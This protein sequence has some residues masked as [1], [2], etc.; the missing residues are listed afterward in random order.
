M[1]KFFKTA[2]LGIMTLAAFEGKAQND[3]N[4]RSIKPVIDIDATEVKSQDRTGTCWSFATT[5]FIESELIRMGKGA[6]NISEMY[7]VR[8]V[9]P[10]KAEVYVR[11]HGKAQFGE[12]SLAH[13]VINSVREYGMVPE[14]VYTG[15]KFDNR[16]NHA[17]MSNILKK[18]LQ[19]VVE[20]KG[21][22]LSKKWKEA[23]NAVLDVYMG[24]APETFEYEGKMYT[25]KSFAD[26]LG[27]NPDDYI[28]VTSFTHQPYYSQFILQVP[29]NF[30]DGM[31]YNLPL[32]EYME[33]IDHALKNGYTLSLDADVSEKG[34]SS[35]HGLAIVPTEYKG[36]DAFFKENVS[37]VSVT[38]ESRQEAYD[39]Y[40]TTDDHLM[41]IT[42]TGKDK[43]G[44]KYFKVKNSWGSNGLG[45][46]GNIY[47]S[48]SYM[49][50][51]SI[52]VLLHKDALPKNV[53]KKLGV[54]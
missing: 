3:K 48:D 26:M 38:S 31:F 13:D 25:P 24:S 37:E 30:S 8:N 21:R 45:F 10:K 28:T 51:K 5:S 44:N 43:Y 41:H 18:I 36:K 46:G 27:M 11:N 40:Q 54:K 19:G 17:E 9:Y 15:L 33:V 42:G 6:H 1:N 29:D 39:N 2:F 22:T 32:D 35:K 16:Y 23:Y 14:S 47:M 4:P 53:K 7:N 50:L 20:N 52:S 12:G 49:R 34:F